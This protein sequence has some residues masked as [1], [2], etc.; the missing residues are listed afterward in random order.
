ML[1]SRKPSTVRNASRSGLAPGRSISSAPTI[2]IVGADEIDL[3]GARPLLEAFLTV[4][5]FRDRSMILV[6]HQHF[7]A[8]VLSEAFDN[9]LLMLEDTSFDVTGHAN[10][11]RAPGVARKD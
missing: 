1:R 6:V 8:V 11:E 2:R 3:P 5:G 7:H 4:D 9:S 10:V